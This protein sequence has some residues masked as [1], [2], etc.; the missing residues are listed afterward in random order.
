MRF[1]TVWRK[2]AAEQFLCWSVG[3]LLMPALDVEMVHLPIVATGR[4]LVM[5]CG[6]GTG[7]CFIEI[8][9]NTG[10]GG[11]G[12]SLHCACDGPYVGDV[13]VYVGDDGLYFGDVGEYSTPVAMM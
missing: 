4:T 8:G 7:R 12:D 10:D 3:G 9:T 6:R 1:S 2:D 13:G 11:R 5:Y